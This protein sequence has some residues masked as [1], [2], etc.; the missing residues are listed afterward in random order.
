M[1]R[2]NEQCKRIVIVC[3][4]DSDRDLEHAFDHAVN[5][6]R[7][8]YVFGHNGNDTGAYYFNVTTDVPPGEWPE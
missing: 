6:V 3:R 1:S 7:A 5:G 4:G 8:G 2:R